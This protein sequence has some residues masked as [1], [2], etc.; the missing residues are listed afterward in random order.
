MSKTENEL[1]PSKEGLKA[2]EAFLSEVTLARMEQ[3]RASENWFKAI[4]VARGEKAFSSIM[5]RA[6]KRGLSVAALTF[7]AG[8]GARSVGPMMVPL[9][10]SIPVLAVGGLGL[11]TLLALRA[12]KKYTSKARGLDVERLSRRIVYAERTFRHLKSKQDGTEEK[13]AFVE[14]RLRKLFQNLVEDTSWP[15]SP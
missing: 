9:V 14:Q 12:P 1:L 4:A 15:G 3:G 8:V 2:F 5:S 6:T 11:A 13:D 7:L 10:A